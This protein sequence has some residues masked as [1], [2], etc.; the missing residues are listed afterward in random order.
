MSLSDTIHEAARDFAANLEAKLLAVIEERAKEIADAIPLPRMSEAAKPHPFEATMQSLAFGGAFNEAWVKITDAVTRR[1]QAVVDTFNRLHGA[2]PGT[3]FTAPRFAMSADETAAL[4]TA[5]SALV[6]LA[7]G[8]A[9]KALLAPA[10]GALDVNALMA[11]LSQA[12]DALPGA[13]SALD[14]ALAANDAKI[15]DEVKAVEAAQAA[16]AV[17]EPAK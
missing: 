1:A 12:H 14:G 13:D 6:T 17:A 4:V 16:P 10:P 11:G 5:V 8:L 2:S 15:A 7:A 9:G 3:A